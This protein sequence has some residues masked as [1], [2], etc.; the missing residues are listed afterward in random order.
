MNLGL[1]QSDIFFPN[2]GKIVKIILDITEDL[3]FAGL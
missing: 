2:E 1:L 3:L